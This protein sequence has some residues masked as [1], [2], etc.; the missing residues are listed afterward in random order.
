MKKFKFEIN[1]S[2]N[3]EEKI[4][5][6]LDHSGVTF[7]KNAISLKDIN[8]LQNIVKNFINKNGERY[9]TILNPLNKEFNFLNEDKEFFIFFKN[10]AE[11]KLSH[12][13]RKEDFLS[14]L[15]V[16]TGEKVDEQS[17]QYH[18]DAFA[19]TIL[20]P[21]F[22]PKSGKSDGHLVIFPN[23]RSFRIGIFNFIEKLFYQNFLTRKLIKILTKKNLKNHILKL[24]PGNIYFFWGYQSLHANLPINKKLLRATLL[25]HFGNVHRNSL[26][27]KLVKNLRHNLETRNIQRKNK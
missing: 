22:I 8:N 7:I 2:E 4:F 27:D 14:V 24:K 19:L 12:R 20:I 16:I 11:K 3:L 13:I 21:I 15:R 18:F 6:K 26:I 9:F 23:I 1:Y 17:H 10:I 5:Q 25:L